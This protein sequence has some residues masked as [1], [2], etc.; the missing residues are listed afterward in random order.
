MSNEE[1]NRPIKK[2]EPVNKFKQ[3]ALIMVGATAIIGC[4]LIIIRFSKIM[5]KDLKEMGL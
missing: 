2:V 1:K 4:A 3:A 5:T